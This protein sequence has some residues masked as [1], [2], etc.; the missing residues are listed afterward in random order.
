MLKLMKKEFLILLGMG[1]LALG[2]CTKTVTIENVPQE[3][4][5]AVCQKDAECTS[6]QALVDDVKKHG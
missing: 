2:G 1:L 3:K 6:P 5:G 4:M